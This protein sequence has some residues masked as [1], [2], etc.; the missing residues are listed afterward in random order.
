MATEADSPHTNILTMV[1]PLSVLMLILQMKLQKP[2][3]RSLKSTTQ[4]LSALLSVQQGKADLL[5]QVYL[6]HLN[7]KKRW[8]FRLSMLYQSKSLL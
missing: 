2:S 6:L 5:L 3:V 8:T 4:S 1:K 7:A